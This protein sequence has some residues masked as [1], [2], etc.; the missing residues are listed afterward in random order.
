MTHTGP[1]LSTLFDLLAA[2]AASFD[3]VNALSALPED[4]WAVV[5]ALGAANLT[6][7]GLSLSAARHQAM[8]QTPGPST[9]PVHPIT[10]SRS[11]A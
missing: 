10:I 3:V 9:I 7:A 8:T 4:F 2:L 6:N 11:P 1:S 5:T